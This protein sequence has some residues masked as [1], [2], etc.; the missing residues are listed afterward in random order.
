[1]ISP[2]SLLSFLFLLL[3]SL[4]R[5]LS[6][7]NS[8]KQ[9]S[10]ASLIFLYYYFCLFYIF[11]I[12]APVFIIFLPLSLGLICSSFSSLSP[13]FLSYET[14]SSL[15]IALRFHLGTKYYISS[16]HKFRNVFSFMFS[17]KYL[18]IS[19][20]ISLTHGFFSVLFSFLT[21]GDF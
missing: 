21:F 9:I 14:S 13:S 11:L 16:I 19:L 3:I 15:I 2:L 18:K 12:S 20:L 6:V 8:L 5:G 4:A 17:L 1:M 7:K 10:L